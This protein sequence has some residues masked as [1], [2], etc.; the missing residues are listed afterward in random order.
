VGLGRAGE[1]ERPKIFSRERRPRGLRWRE[2]GCDRYPKE[3][4]NMN[5]WKLGTVVFF[6]ALIGWVAWWSL[7]RAVEKK[8]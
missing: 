3:V 8:S 4:M 1:R 5:G 7:K 6:L 2:S